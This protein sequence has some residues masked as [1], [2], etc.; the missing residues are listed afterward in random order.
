MPRL[1]R[2][3]RVDA[4]FRQ[5]LRT[6]LWTLNQSISA[7][8]AHAPRLANRDFAYGRPPSPQPIP[9][10][11]AA[12]AARAPGGRGR[13]GFVDGY[14]HIP[15]ITKDLRVPAFTYSGYS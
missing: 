9:S 1:A 3:V 6:P 4:L 5:Q 8:L 13:I 2:F 11:A 10:N 12:A 15:R 14:E 7:P